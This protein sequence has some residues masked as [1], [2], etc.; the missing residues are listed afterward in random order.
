MKIPLV[1]VSLKKAQKLSRHY[2]GWGETISKFFP[3]LGFSLEQ[4][5]FNFEPREWISI[6]LYSFLNY[7][8]VVFCA[9]FI[10]A[11]AAKAVFAMA[12]MTSLLIG[13]F[14]AFGSFFYI[15]FY[16][17]M[18]V[19]RRVKNLERNLPYA[20]HQL[21]IQVR[22]GMPLYN[23]FVSLAR[24]NYGIL[25]E[26]FRDAVNEINTGRSE[27]EVLET[28]ARENPSLNLRR[29]L[30]QMVNA[31][32]SGAD[33]GITLKEIVNQMVNEQKTEIKKYGAQMNTIALFY[34][35]FVVIFPTLG[36]LFLLILTS[37]MG[38]MFDIHLLL[39]GI[40]MFL[41]LIQFVFIGMVKTKRPAGI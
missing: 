14:I 40:L 15:S 28:M 10:I 18:F 9:M 19:S 7:F 22:S 38:G 1:P 11:I 2:F 17:R 33:I 37:F 41:V 31:M 8:A 21:L 30:W 20:L 34:M 16:P 13:F 23:S 36:I 27:I 6:A 3:T 12:L 4:A 5:G 24:E 29:I 39:G 25:S 26:A 32:K 35:I